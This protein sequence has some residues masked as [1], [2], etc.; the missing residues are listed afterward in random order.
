MVEEEAWSGKIKALND[1]CQEINK[2]YEGR[3]YKLGFFHKSQVEFLELNARFMTN[4]VFQNLVNNIKRDRQLASIPLLY[5]LE[6]NRYMVLSG[7]HRLQAGIAAGEEIFMALYID[8]ELSES[9]RVAIQLSH[10]SLEGQDDPAI[11]RE[12]W[13]K[14]EDIDLKSYAGLD[15]MALDEIPEV[16][17]PTIKVPGLDYRT[18]AFIFLPEEADRL[19]QC[20]DTALD[21]ASASQIYTIRK[22][23]FERFIQSLSEVEASYNIKAPSLAF[24]YIL[25]VFQAHRTDL[26]E[27]WAKEMSNSKRKVPISSITGTDIITVGEA[28]NLQRAIQKMKDNKEFPDNGLDG[29]L[30]VLINNYIKKENKKG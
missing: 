22:T 25:D 20:Y 18:I 5:K 23:E 7:N 26:S 2:F 12:L 11:L 30:G 1:S 16:E 28:H 8:Q 13:S 4:T 24:M 14:I 15:D 3:P 27:G 29:I 6:D 9:Q 17:L 10:N 21:L 19:Q